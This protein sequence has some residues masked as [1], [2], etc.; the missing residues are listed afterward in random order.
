MVSVE[1]LVFAMSLLSLKSDPSYLYLMPMP[2]SESL[3]ASDSIAENMRLNRVGAS[4]QPC[5]TPLETGNDVGVVFLQSSQHAIV[6]LTCA[7]LR[8]YSP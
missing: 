2:A 7:V 5:F 4:T 1:T 6:E 3:K 8:H